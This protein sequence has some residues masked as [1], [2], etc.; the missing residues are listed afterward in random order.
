MIIYTFAVIFQQAAPGQK[1][2]AWGR[3][4][5]EE[6]VSLEANRI[7]GAKLF[8]GCLTCVWSVDVGR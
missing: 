6:P 1:R 3:P 2:A 5:E 4:E 8:R 7:Y